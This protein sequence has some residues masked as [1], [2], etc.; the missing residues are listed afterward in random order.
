MRSLLI[1]ITLVLTALAAAFA[2]SG[3]YCLNSGEP[4]LADGL[5][6]TFA[7]PFALGAFIALAGVAATPRERNHA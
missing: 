5:I 3:Y 6:M 1:N 2:Y 7:I 4:D